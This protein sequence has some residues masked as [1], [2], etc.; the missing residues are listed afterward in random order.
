M[1]HTAT[2]TDPR[3]PDAMPMWESFDHARAQDAYRAA[4]A[5]IE[6]A[7]PDDRIV[8]EGHGVYAVLTTADP[9]ATPVATIVISH[10][11]DPETAPAIIEP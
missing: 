2:I 5:Y 6:T 7:Q 8:D 4:H 9:N 11:E 3:E 1:T 10:G